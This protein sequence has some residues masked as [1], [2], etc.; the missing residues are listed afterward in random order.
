MTT[1]KTTT[2]KLKAARWDYAKML[3]AV[4][5]VLLLVDWSQSTIWK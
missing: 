5:L 3:L 4:S 2:A 1:N